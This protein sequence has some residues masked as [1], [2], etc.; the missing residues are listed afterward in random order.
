MQHL[1]R[2]QDYEY[3]VVR[4]YAI[5]W[6]GVVFYCVMMLTTSAELVCEVRCHRSD[7]WYTSLWGFSDRER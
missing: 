3:V 7:H 5:M 2:V 1:F 6:A 4:R